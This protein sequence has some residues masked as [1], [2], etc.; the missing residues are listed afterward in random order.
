MSSSSRLSIVAGRTSPQRRSPSKSPTKKKAPVIAVNLGTANKFQTGNIPACFG[1]AASTITADKC[2][3][4]LYMAFRKVH[5]MGDFNPTSSEFYG[6]N[7]QIHF[8]LYASFLSTNVIPHRLDHSKLPDLVS[9]NPNNTNYMTFKTLLGYFGK[10]KEIFRRAIN[11][12][13][14]PKSGK[15]AD[16]DPDWYSPLFQGLEKKLVAFHMQMACQ[17]NIDIGTEKC[18]PLY[19]DCAPTFS[20]CAGD[21][22]KLQVTPER[23]WWVKPARVTDRQAPGPLGDC[24]HMLT[25]D[26]VI[27]NIMQ[28]ADYIRSVHPM[29]DRFKLVMARSSVARG[30]E[31]KFNTVAD[32]RY[33]HFFQAL[34]TYW[35]ESKVQKEKYSCAHVNDARSCLI[36][37]YHA[38][39]CYMMMENGFHATQA[40]LDSGL[41]N[42]VF[43]GLH[44][45]SNESVT[46]ALTNLIRKNLP[47]NCSGVNQFSAKSLRKATVSELSQHPQSTFFTVI[48]RSGHSSNNNVDSYLDPS[49]M[50]RS[51]PGA[52][53]LAGH[54]DAQKVVFP[55]RLEAVGDHNKEMMM[56]LLTAAI[57]QD[58]LHP[59]FKPTGRLFQVT[60]VMF[61][62]I[63]M[64]HV[65]F[66][67]HYGIQHPVAQ[68]LIIAAKKIMLRDPTHLKSPSMV[69]DHW[70][71]LIQRAWVQDNQS[72]HVTHKDDLAATKHLLNLQQ[73]QLRDISGCLQKMKEVLDR[74]SMEIVQLE[75]R[76]EAA[77]KQADEQQKIAAEQI[78][79]LVLKTVQL[80]TPDAAA[81][82]AK[83]PRFDEEDE[84]ATPQKN[85]SSSFTAVT[86]SMD[87]NSTISSKS[88]KSS[89]IATQPHP[90]DPNYKFGDCASIVKA[91]STQANSE[92]TMKGI[93]TAVMLKQLFS[94]LLFLGVAQS[95]VTAIGIPP[96]YNSSKFLTRNVLE[97]VAYSMSEED[98]A[99][100]SDQPRN[101]SEEVMKALFSRAESNAMKQMLAFEAR[102]EGN[103]N[104]EKR[105][106]GRKLEGYVTGLGKRV[107]EYK[108]WIK[109]RL[110][111]DSK[112]NASD[113]A[114]QDRQAVLAQNPIGTPP[115][116][117]SISRMFAKHQG[118]LRKQEE[119]WT[120]AIGT[121]RAPDATEEDRVMAWTAAEMAFNEAVVVDA[122][123]AEADG[124]ALCLSEEPHGE[125]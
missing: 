27:D 35:V 46:S 26:L 103:N 98:W 14:L 106:S 63:L 5:D 88:S 72:A 105:T 15:K 34:E 10:T 84:E 95:Q 41:G 68:H 55:P 115:G 111:P 59:D 18:L 1:H 112:E 90:M 96:P 2:A 62:T 21:V 56:E 52:K 124:E 67:D 102:P 44:A 85:L 80:K 39:G 89:S 121:E 45:C 109:S 86:S 108:K 93:S 82:K 100:L 61:A 120:A 70:S 113:I 22:D 107:N 28:K 30:G 79:R 118:A 12:E 20:Q 114:L 97:L 50:E 76:Y 94:R 32:W 74:K 119:T 4:D 66:V 29:E 38:A 57:V 24:T 33:D 25:F 71:G 23:D 51:L 47:K 87:C 49:S 125:V 7:L 13:D 123:L 60:K 110:S 92:G 116:N 19:R 81:S 69:L 3:W 75:D 16:L 91:R 37:F 9:S 31:I 78:H 42:C 83:R 36:D 101:H 117:H 64:H 8:T 53:I 48:G 6:E 104:K 77:Q 122:E 54:A 40:Q 73:V 99:V 11:H 58:G 65:S 43:P 17:E